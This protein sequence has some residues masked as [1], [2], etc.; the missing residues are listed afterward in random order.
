[1][2]DPDREQAFL[3]I[4]VRDGLVRVFDASPDPA[5]GDLSA[6]YVLEV[7]GLSI[8][9]PLR[10]ADDS[11]GPEAYIHIDNEATHPITLALEVNNS[12]DTRFAL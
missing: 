7:F 5:D 8:L 10:A 1:M 3:Q 4:R 2:T 12:A 6:M 9:V 11:K